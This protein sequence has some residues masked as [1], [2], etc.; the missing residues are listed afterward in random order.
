MGSSALLKF[1]TLSIPCLGLLLACGPVARAEELVT[2]EPAQELHGLPLLFREDFQSGKATRWEM[3]DPKAWKIVPH[4][5]NQ[6]LYQF[7]QSM[8][9]PTFRSPYNRALIKDLVLSDCVLDVR[10]QSTGA[11][12]DHRDMCLFFGFQDPEHFYY[13]HFG[14]KADKYANQIFI[15]DG[16]DRKKISLESTSGTPWNDNWHHARVVRKATDGMILV[17]FD[18]MDKPVMKA[19][20]KTFETGLVGVGSF[21]DS[22][23]FDNIYVYGT[24]AFPAKKRLTIPGNR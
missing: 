15:V 7:Q 8:I 9:K 1:V 12:V 4:R 24:K 21:D 19:L 23:Y 3:S 22:G 20:D 14:K 18:E 6:V 13:V 11:N 17:Y 2:E 10:L 16:A 5:R